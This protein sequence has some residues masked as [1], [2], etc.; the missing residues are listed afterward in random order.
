MPLIYPCVLFFISFH[1]LVRANQNKKKIIVRQTKKISRNPK[2]QTGVNK[3]RTSYT[4][5]K[6]V[7]PQ[8]NQKKKNQ[9]F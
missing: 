9:I 7:Q 8:T 6:H 3:N 5:T 4:N 2:M 1:F